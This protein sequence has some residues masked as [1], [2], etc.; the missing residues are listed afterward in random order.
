MTEKEA[1][2]WLY[3]H[4]I[5][6]GYTDK[7]GNNPKNHESYQAK[8]PITRADLVTMFYRVQNM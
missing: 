7:K 5:V 6:N 3:D 1:I 8:K 2:Q 4:Q